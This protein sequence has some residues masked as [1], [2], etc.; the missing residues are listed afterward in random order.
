MHVWRWLGYV[1]TCA[2]CHQLLAGHYA[3]ACR[4]SWLFGL[5]ASAYCTLV[6]KGLHALRAAPLI[7]VPALQALQLRQPRE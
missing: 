6:H 4:P 2:L 1:S 5:D 3:D 7:A